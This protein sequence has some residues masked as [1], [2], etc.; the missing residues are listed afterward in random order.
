M[1]KMGNYVKYL[2]GFTIAE[3]LVVLA[4]TSIAIT[5]SYG[6]LSYI[7]KLFFDYRKQ[8]NFLNEFTEFKK[9]MDHESLKADIVI[10]KNENE[11]EIKR[12]SVSSHLYIMESVILM[13]KNG[14]CDTFHIA[15]RSIKKEYELMH[16]PTWS[17]KLLRRLELETDF[18]KQ[19]FNFY[20]SKEYS[21]D[22]K[23]KL[24]GVK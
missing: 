22:V 2:R 1:R 16:N 18:K 20:F 4:L 8:N 3:L 9:R 15:A 24:D 14:H 10:E 23:L 17:N 21:A 11:F 19:K 12:D 6:T 13:K 7:Q 5:F